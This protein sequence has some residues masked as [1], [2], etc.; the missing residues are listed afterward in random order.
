VCVCVCRN[1]VLLAKASTFQV[2]ESC[3]TAFG[4]TQL[5]G[6]AAQSPPKNSNTKPR[7]IWTH[8]HV[9]SGFQTCEPNAHMLAIVEIYA[10]FKYVI[11]IS[12]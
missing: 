3:Y 7:K 6:P 4:R 10:P 12:F 8:I 2:P 5:I 9:P 1:T 11:K